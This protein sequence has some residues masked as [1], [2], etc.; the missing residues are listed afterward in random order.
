MAIHDVDMDQIGTAALRRRNIT[1][2]CCEV[3]R[4]DRRC[5]LDLP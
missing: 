3:G 1:A 4:K 2:E 5:E